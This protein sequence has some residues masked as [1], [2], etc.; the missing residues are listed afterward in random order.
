[1]EGIFIMVDGILYCLVF[2]WIGFMGFYFFYCL[3]H[4]NIIL[5]KHYDAINKTA[6]VKQ[7]LS[8]S[9]IVETWIEQDSGCITHDDY[10]VE[11]F[12]N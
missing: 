1:M 8:E 10:R 12:F 3:F 6:T 5:I 4:Q 9:L 2:S 7:K 11:Y